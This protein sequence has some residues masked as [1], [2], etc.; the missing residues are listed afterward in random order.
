MVYKWYILPIGG[1][2]GTYHLLGEPETAI[3]GLKGLN[4][5]NMGV[6]GNSDTVDGRNPIP[7][8]LGKKNTL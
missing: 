1:L 2:Y 8:H 6:G 5:L 7:N 4:I 3:E